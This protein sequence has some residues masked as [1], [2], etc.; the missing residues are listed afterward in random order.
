MIYKSVNK[1]EGIISEK[2][3]EKHPVDKDLSSWEVWAGPHSPHLSNLLRFGFRDVF[4]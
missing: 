2:E 3:K 1:G 4:L